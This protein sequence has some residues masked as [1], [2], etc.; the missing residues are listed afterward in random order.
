MNFL[1]GKVHLIE[2][3]Y[4][5]WC[6]LLLCTSLPSCLIER[7]TVQFGVCWG[8]F[9]CFCGFFYLGFSIAYG[10]VESGT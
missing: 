1:I 9:V 8:F 4:F 10:T 3:R 2:T 5:Y 6:S 7:N